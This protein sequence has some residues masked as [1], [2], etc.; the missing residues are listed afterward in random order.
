MR[1]YSSIPTYKIVLEILIENKEG[2][3]SKASH[4]FVIDN[5]RDADIDVSNG[6]RRVDPV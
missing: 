3:S 2:V 5:Y 6:T 1:L 4:N